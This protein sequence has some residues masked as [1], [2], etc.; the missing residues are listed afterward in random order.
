MKAS[1]HK[2]PPARH[3]RPDS[4]EAFLPDPGDGPARVRDDFAEEMAEDF[5]ASANSGEQT[6]GDALDGE[7]PEEM[8]GPFVFTSAKEEF[9]KGIDKSN[10]RSAEKEAFPM[11]NAHPDD[12]EE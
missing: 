7:V 9:A 3:G 4:G 12:A 5:L 1:K 6:L 11:A 8:G 10:P 2:H